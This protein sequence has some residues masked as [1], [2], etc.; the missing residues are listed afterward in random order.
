MNVF[1]TGATDGIGLELAHLYAPKCDRL[2]LLGRKPRAALPKSLRESSIYC[3]LDLSETDVHRKL[4]QFLLQY[5]IDAFDVAIHN[6]ATAYY[7]SIKMQTNEHVRELIRTNVLS[8]M[9]MSQVLIPRLQR[10]KGKLVF[11]SSVASA[12]PAPKYA[13]YAATKAALDGFAR[14]LRIELEGFVD[15]QVVYPGP[16]NT[17][18]H[19]KAE[20]PKEEMSRKEFP[21]A[22][23]VAQKIYHGIG[24]NRREYT[25]G[26]GNL[27]LRKIGKYFPG[28][29]DRIAAQRPRS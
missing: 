24:Q 11:V 7:G 2:V 19:R 29:V 18:M 6:A 16:T 22:E 25:I 17:G 21:D 4:D 23:L 3:Q 15:V 27:M 9:S 20:I 8:P 14:S 10:R 1:I 26:F 5:E 13:V 28:T 12:F